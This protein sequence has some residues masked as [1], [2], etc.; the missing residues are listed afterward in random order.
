MSKTG[1]KFGRRGFLKGAVASGVAGIA[2]SS[3]LVLAQ[4]GGTSSTGCKM[5]WEIAPPPYP[6][7]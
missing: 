2:A 4:K 6:G 3:P 1:F 5:S 7:Q